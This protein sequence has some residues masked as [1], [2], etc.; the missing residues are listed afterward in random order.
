MDVSFVDGTEAIVGSLVVSIGSLVDDE[1]RNYLHLVEVVL[2]LDVVLPEGI[3]H[4]VQKSN[5]LVHRKIYPQQLASTR[6]PILHVVQYLVQL[7]SKTLIYVLLF[8]L[9][10]RQILL[11]LTVTQL[12]IILQD[13]PIDGSNCI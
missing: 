1:L 4:V 3:V 2:D 13:L 6:V 8:D 12:E 11:I 5:H 9:L 10:P 7:H